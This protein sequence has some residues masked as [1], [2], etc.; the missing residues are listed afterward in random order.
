MSL[1]TTTVLMLVTLIGVIMMGFPIGFSLA[2]I[3]TLFGIIFVGPQIADV[4]ML[5]IYVA[6]S[7][8]QIW[9]L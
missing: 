1:E 2:G 7:A 6:M 4:F 9:K 3:A 5:R 8:S